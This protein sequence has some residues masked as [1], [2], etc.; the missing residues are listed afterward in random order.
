MLGK[1][2]RQLGEG[3]MFHDLKERVRATPIAA[4]NDIAI[5]AIRDGCNQSLDFLIEEGL[6]HRE[7]VVRRFSV[8][9]L[10][11][12]PADHSRE[13]KILGA[14]NEMVYREKNRRLKIFA[15]ERYTVFQQRIQKAREIS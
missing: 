14:V 12:I 4:I 7:P 3:K 5:L 13:D 11:D 15:L 8:D 1:Y 2:E 9:Y 10:C 6:A